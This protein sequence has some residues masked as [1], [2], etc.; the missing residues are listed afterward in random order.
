MGDGGELL[1]GEPFEKRFYEISKT[2]SIG[3]YIFCSVRS[4]FHYNT[5]T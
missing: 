3:E 2:I 1:G 5:L 4:L